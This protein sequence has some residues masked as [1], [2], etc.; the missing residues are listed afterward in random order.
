MNKENLITI[1]RNRMI[2]VSLLITRLDGVKRPTQEQ[3]F[4]NHG[5]IAALHAEQLFLAGMIEQLE[6][7]EVTP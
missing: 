5:M 2:V 1:L 4:R 7:E 6:R 3:F